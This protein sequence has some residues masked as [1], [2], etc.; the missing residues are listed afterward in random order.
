VSLGAGHRLHARRLRAGRGVVLGP[1]V[2]R[3]EERV[4]ERRRS[5]EIPYNAESPAAAAGA[6]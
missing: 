2:D 3:I 1:V 4:K 6:S 5:A